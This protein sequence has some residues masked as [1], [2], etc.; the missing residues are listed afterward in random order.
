MTPVE[1]L[2]KA[3]RTIGGQTATA[4]V[5]SEKTGRNIRQQHVWNW[6]NRDGGVPPEYAVVLEE[7]ILLQGGSLTRQQLCPKFYGSG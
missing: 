7:I 5:I 4:L 1:A 2:R 6:L 3:I